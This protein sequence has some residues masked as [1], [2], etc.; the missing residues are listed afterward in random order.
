MLRSMGYKQVRFSS[1]LF[2]F[3]FC[4]RHPGTTRSICCM[5]WGATNM[6]IQHV[7]RPPRSFAPPC[8]LRCVNE[9]CVG[10]QWMAVC[11]APRGCAPFCPQELKRSLSGFQNFAI[12]F[13]GEY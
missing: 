5:K 1:L 9:S 8:A 7:G 3:F 4:N 13:T 11:S 2:L 6:G 10:G 12:S